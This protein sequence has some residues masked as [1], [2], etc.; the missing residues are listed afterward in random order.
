[1]LS[2]MLC[3]DYRI[4]RNKGENH[5]TDL[6][7]LNLVKFINDGWVLGSSQF[8]ILP[9]LAQ[10]MTLGSKVVKRDPKIIILL[11]KSKFV[12]YSLGVEFIAQ[13]Y[14]SDAVSQKVGNSFASLVYVCPEWTN[15]HASKYANLRLNLSELTSN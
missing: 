9:K 6:D 2:F 3:Q 8:L 15:G 14:I 4:F 10:K 11:H 1:M 12:T 13:P 7:K 5:F